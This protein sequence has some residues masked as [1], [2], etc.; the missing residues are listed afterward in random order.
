MISVHDN[1]I[2][3]YCVDCENRRIVLHTRFPNDPATEFTDVIFTGVIAHH[4]E[5]VLAH[6][7]LFDITEVAVRDI[8]TDFATL[9]AAG[10]SHCWPGGTERRDADE[11]VRILEER[12]S[13]I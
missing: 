12:G 11:L 13:R 4:F 7:F 8:V 2:Y 9:F 5:H 10:K 3:A 6:N 1:F